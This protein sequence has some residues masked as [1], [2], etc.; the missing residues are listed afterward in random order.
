[1]RLLQP[2]IVLMDMTMP[3][4]DGLEATRRLTAEYPEVKVIGLS[5]HDPLEM[6]PQMQAAGAFRFLHKSTPVDELIA[7]IRAAMGVDVH[8]DTEKDE[9]Q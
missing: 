4:L 2:D 5:M 8:G 7:A 3:R 1:V 9:P 6:Q